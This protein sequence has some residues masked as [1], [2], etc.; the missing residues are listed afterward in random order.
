MRLVFNGELA[1]HGV[2]EGTKAVCG[3]SSDMPKRTKPR[4][5]AKSLALVFAPHRVKRCFKVG[6]FL[7]R[8]S[9]V[10]GDAFAYLAAVLEFVCA[11]VLELAGNCAKDAKKKRITPRH[12][13]QAILNDEELNKLFRSA[14]IAQQA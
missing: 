1:K 10:N 7:A 3:F 5:T 2:S 14:I 6:G 12:I 4:V 11:E 13:N 8:I 9:R